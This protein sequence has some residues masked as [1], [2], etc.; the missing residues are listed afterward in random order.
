M[1]LRSIVI[2]VVLV[3]SLVA[4]A[5]LCNDRLEKKFYQQGIQD[6]TDKVVKQVIEQVKKTGQLQ[7]TIPDVGAVVLAVQRSTTTPIPT[8]APAPAVVAPEPK[9]IPIPKKGE[10]PRIDLSKVTE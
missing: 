4:N 5:W 10:S 9:V 6:G 3:I 1:N 2:L 8:S 7:V